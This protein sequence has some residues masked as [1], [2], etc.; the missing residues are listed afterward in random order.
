[1]RNCIACGWATDREFR[2]RRGH[3]AVLCSDCALA[4]VCSYQNL[5]PVNP[6]EFQ[7]LESQLSDTKR[8]RDDLRYELRSAERRLREIEQKAAGGG[9]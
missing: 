6:Q 2:D 4:I 5:E 8:E 3:V 9:A 1:V 7:R